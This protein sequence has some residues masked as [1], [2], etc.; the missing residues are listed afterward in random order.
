MGEGVASHPSCSLRPHDQKKIGRAPTL[1]LCSRNARPEKGLVRRP[2]VDQHE[3]PS[4]RRKASELGRIILFAVARCAQSRATL[5]APL[6]RCSEQKR[7]WR[8]MI[9]CARATRGLR[10]P[11]PGLMARLGAQLGIDWTTFQKVQCL[12]FLVL[13]F[14]SGGEGAL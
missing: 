1:V 4:K 13:N 12:Q 11:S 6:S 10:R 8:L 9:F 7:R 14:R 3:C 2:H 5:A